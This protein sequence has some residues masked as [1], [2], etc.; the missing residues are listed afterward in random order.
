ML[1]VIPTECTHWQCGSESADAAEWPGVQGAYSLNLMSIT[2][3]AKDDLNSW[4]KQQMQNSTHITWFIS[5]ATSIPPACANLKLCKVRAKH[6]LVQFKHGIPN[7][8]APHL[9]LKLR[10]LAACLRI[11]L[12][13][14]QPT[15]TSHASK[16]ITKKAIMACRVQGRIFNRTPCH[17]VH[18]AS[19]NARRAAACTA[20]CIFGLKCK[21]AL[22]ALSALALLALCKQMHACIHVHPHMY[23]H[24]LTCTHT[25]HTRTR[26]THTRAQALRA[27]SI[28]DTRMPDW[29][30]Q[31]IQ[32][33]AP[34]LLI[35]HR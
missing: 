35:K 11:C 33:A 6:S 32:A 19:V 22:L 17:M 28:C 7:L 8:P 23:T 10:N 29:A 27:L 2:H 34:K 30:V 31:E 25:T 9:R 26:H 3:R 18:L 20:V 21:L 24:T 16:F 4:S 14:C 13:E 12:M 15:C 5:I 1:A